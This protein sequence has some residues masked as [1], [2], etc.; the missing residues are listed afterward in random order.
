MTTLLYC[1]MG[2]F[3]KEKELC[4]LLDFLFGFNLIIVV[5]VYLTFI[6]RRCFH[7]ILLILWN[8]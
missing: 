4:K 8:L 7:D 2:D 3:Q 1:F 6:V 5:Y